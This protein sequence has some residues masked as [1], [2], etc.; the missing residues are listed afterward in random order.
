MK[1]PVSHREPAISLLPPI[2]YVPLWLTVSGG[3]REK[4]KS[5]SCQQAYLWKH[6]K[7]LAAYD[8]RIPYLGKRWLP[9]ITFAPAATND[10]IPFHPDGYFAF[11]M[12]RRTIS[13]F[14]G[15]KLANY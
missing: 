15:C 2:Y 1:L 9:Q 12:S 11:R 14:F 7:Q 3:K 6:T 13:V 10:R 5:R 8:L 4:P